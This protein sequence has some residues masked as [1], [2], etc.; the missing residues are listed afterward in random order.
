MT[1][2]EI[3]D[4]LKPVKPLSRERL[5]FY[6][7]KFRIKPVGIRQIPAQYP[8]DTPQRLLLRFGLTNGRSVTLSRSTKARR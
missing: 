5:Y 8:N 4:E 7:R 3:R 6:F 2:Q 1:I